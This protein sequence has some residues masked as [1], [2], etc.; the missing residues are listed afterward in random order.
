MLF[1]GVASKK[2]AANVRGRADGRTTV[3]EAEVATERKAM[4]LYYRQSLGG[5]LGKTLHTEL[6]RDR[7]ISKCDVID[8]IERVLEEENGKI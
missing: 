4:R 7:Q 3:A 2:S 1:V 6:E 8:T 5:G